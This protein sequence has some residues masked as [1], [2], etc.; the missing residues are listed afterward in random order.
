MILRPL[1]TSYFLNAGGLFFSSKAPG[2]V[3][4][5][6]YLRGSFAPSAL[7]RYVGA[8]GFPH[9]YVTKRQRPYASHFI[10]A[11]PLLYVEKIV[12]FRKGLNIL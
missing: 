12:R 6:T 4:S 1:H 5:A 3:F 8:C 9:R 10:K 2:L 7:P 11:H